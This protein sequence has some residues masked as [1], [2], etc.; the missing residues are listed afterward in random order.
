MSG[1][2]LLRSKSETFQPEETLVSSQSETPV[3]PQDTTSHFF[4]LFNELLPC[5]NF[6]FICASQHLIIM[7]VLSYMLLSTASFGFQN[8]HRS[9][10][11]DGSLLFLKPACGLLQRIPC[12][13]CFV[14]GEEQTFHSHLWK[15]SLRLNGVIKLANSSII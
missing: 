9:T 5:P 2:Y 7:Y 6:V 12:A 13:G 4:L 14:V 3:R 11:R 1:E 15:I 8:C 10:P